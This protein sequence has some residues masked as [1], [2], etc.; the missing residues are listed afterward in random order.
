MHCQIVFDHCCISRRHCQIFL[1]G[2]DR[3]LRLVDGFFLYRDSDLGEVRRRLRSERRPLGFRVSLNGVY[4]NRR[5]LQEGAVAVLSEGDEVVF[6]CGRLKSFPRCVT[7]YG[8]VVESIILS[9]FTGTL[10]VNGQS[11]TRAD[12]LQNLCQRVLRSGDPISYLRCSLNSKV[13]TISSVHGVT[14]YGSDAS[15]PV[16]GSEGHSRLNDETAN[17]G[18]NVTDEM[19]LAVDYADKEETRP[20]SLERGLSLG[21]SFSNGQTFFLNRL[22]FMA[23]GTSYQHTEVTLMEL[24][25]PV[26]SLVKV[27][28][29][30]FTCDVS[31][32]LSCCQ[33]PNHL[34]VTIA[35]HSAEKCWS[36]SCHDRTSA[37]YSNYPNLLLVYPLFP[38]EIAFGK[39]RSKKGVACHHPKLLVLQREESVRVVVTSANLV[40]KQ[41][42]QITNTVWWQ[43]FPRRDVPDYSSLFATIKDL[44]SDFAAQL[45]G[46]IASLITD[47]PSQA[48]WIKD[49][50]RYDFGGASAYLIASVPG[51]HAL[52]TISSGSDV[53]QPLEHVVLSK[54]TT[55]T[56]Y[57]GSVQTF[58]VGLSHRF[59][60]ATDSRGEQLKK[61]ASFLGKF[62][63]SSSRLVEVV[64]KRNHNIPADANAISILVSNVDDASNGDSVQL[65][66]LPRDVAKWAAPLGDH[67]FLDFSAFVCPKDALAAA[68]DGTNTKVQ[69]LLSIAQGPMFSEI[70][71]LL[72]PEHFPA[73]CLFIASIQRCL[74]LW[75]L[76]EVMSLY[77]WP[78][79]L[80]TDFVY[81]SSSVGTS[82]NPQFLVAF[83]AAA[84][85]KTVQLSESEESDPG[86]GCW[87]TDSEVRSPSIKILF[88]TIERVKSSAEGIQL[89]KY[90]LS[91]S[92]KTWQRLRTSGILHDSIP[93]PAYRIGYP[94]HVKV[95][96]RRFQSKTSTSA[97]GWI[98]CG[99]HNFSSAAWGLMVPPSSEK[100]GSGVHNSIVSGSRLRIC[101]Y[102]LGIVF[103]IP[104]PNSAKGSVGNLCN[105]DDIKLPFVV[106][107]PRY[108]GGDRPA[109]SRAMAECFTSLTEQDFEGMDEEDIADDEIIGPSEYIA[110]ENEGDKIYAEM[111][112]TQVGSS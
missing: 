84:G 55:S 46:F 9:D 74:G 112:W 85:K 97:F 100:V 18:Q 40:S 15:F 43:D 21:S 101:N 35:F 56:K 45:V 83:S 77:K 90:L 24:F 96:R 32:F 65:G 102:E 29:A 3:R 64:L 88:P 109:T 70:S 44:K 69:C 8:F 19:N 106:P 17:H 41:W 110:E 72:Q 50:A 51:M 13:E 42:N 99:S 73:L 91:F 33:I 26:E 57:L 37:P 111:L 92:E 10:D 79:L 59:H 49:L 94:M 52:H 23:H 1:D 107:A 27:F 105:L 89:S 78:E 86:W 31:W 34:P 4:V 104:P 60:N 67:G 7:K 75:R 98:Y 95:A 38:D 87:N 20:S 62:K 80:E 81:A 108:C 30:T 48:H 58:V 22:E 66:F 2:V 5:K 76:K 16:L 11:V 25:D 54:L 68:L 61:L 12:L 39:D 82:M 36:S 28:I 53:F 63:E 71:R 6:G 47:V 93:N 103:I 14:N